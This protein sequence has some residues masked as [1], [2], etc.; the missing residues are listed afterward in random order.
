LK[1][2]IALLFAVNALL[3]A[4]NSGWINLWESRDP[5]RL[6]RQVDAERIAVLSP[7]TVPAPSPATNGAPS[8]SGEVMQALP[9]LGESGKP[10]LA[11][12][13][14]NGPVSTPS[15]GSDAVAGAS[16]KP[17]S[18]T[19]A[20]A[21]AAGAAAAN[22]AQICLEF[23]AMESDRAQTI[24]TSM[25]QTG[26]NVEM[27]SAESNPSYIVHLAPSESLKEAQRK[28][29]ELKRLGVSDAFL[30]Q[31]GPLKLGISLGLFRAEEG[32]KAMVQQLAAK[33]IK[34]A[35]ISAGNALKAGKVIIKASGTEVQLA[36][37]RQAASEVN[38]SLKLCGA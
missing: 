21:A 5:E 11:S 16:I 20:S 32:A 34:S 2:F 19:E 18:T 10:A 25:K 30:M 8:G 17:A 28:L 6:K 37:V 26:I 22:A 14:G 1:L 29:V 23:P 4:M 9:A 33:G 24:E 3:L 36:R 13:P 38:L 31:E 27:K 12:I 35:K 7:S 15:S